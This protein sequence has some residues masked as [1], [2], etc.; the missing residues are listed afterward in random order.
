MGLGRSDQLP[1]CGEERERQS[2]VLERSVRGRQAQGRGAARAAGP[3]DGAVS[4]G[5]GQ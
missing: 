1:V 4:V 3:G 2:R 5:L